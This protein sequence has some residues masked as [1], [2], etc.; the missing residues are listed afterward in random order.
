MPGDSLVAGLTHCLVNGTDIADGL[1]TACAISAN[2]VEQVGVG[3]TSAERLQEIL[4]QVQLEEISKI[5]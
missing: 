5:E 4:Q 3:I 1:K 2:A